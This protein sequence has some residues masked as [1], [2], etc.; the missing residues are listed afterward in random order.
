M[1]HEHPCPRVVKWILAH[2]LLNQD[3]KDLNNQNEL[4]KQ[5]IKFRDELIAEHGLVLVGGEEEEEDIR[6]D[7]D[8]NL[9]DGEKKKL[10][11]KR[12][13]RIAKMAL[14]SQEGAD[15]LKNAGSGNLDVRLKKIAEEKQDLLDEIYRL[16]LDLEEE[17]Q[18]AY[19]LDQLSLMRTGANGP[20]MKL[21]E[22]QREA[23]KQVSDYKYRL[24]RA[25]Q[26][27]T[28]L[29]S[30]VSRLEGQLN[31]YKTQ[32]ESAEATEDELKA[33]KRKLQREYREALARIEELETANSHLQ[34]RIDKL[35]T[36]K[37]VLIKT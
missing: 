29:Q 23:N 18:K 4:L 21:L 25:E 1:G 27:I 22:V 14:V 2:D 24:K 26:E 15:I 20:E 7:D 37:S 9:S 36:V 13:K 6:E 31:R 12:Q 16:R 34:K 28:T 5:C 30:S 33:E 10:E 35:K 3:F 32:A 17:R 11:S 19:K 8:D